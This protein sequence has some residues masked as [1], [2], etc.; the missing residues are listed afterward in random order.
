M[1]PGGKP[2]IRV[3]Q[4]GNRKV[5]FDCNSLLAFAVEPE[6][7][8]PLKEAF[9]KSVERGSKFKPQFKPM[10]PKEKPSTICL[11]VTHACNQCCLYCFQQS[12]YPEGGNMDF[13]TAKLAID[14]FFQP[15]E[16]GRANISF[17][18]G[19]PLL[20]WELIPWVV[21][22]TRKR[23]PDAKRLHFHITTN[24]TLL[25]EEKVEYLDRNNFSLIVSIDGP[26]YI[27]NKFRPMKSGKDSLN[28]TLKGL[29]LLKGRKIAKRT[30]LRGTFTSDYIR[31]RERLEYLNSL[32]E[33]GC[34][35]NVSVEP[36][37][38]NEDACVWEKPGAKPSR[39]KEI[40]SEYRKAAEW[41]IAR[42]KSGGQQLQ[43]KRPR[44]F[45]FEKTLE[46]ILFSEPAGTECGAGCGYLSFNPKGQIF[47]C[48]REH[49]TAIGHLDYGIDEE[50]R[51]K[52][53]ENR[54]YARKGCMD[55][56]ARYVCGGGCRQD[57]IEAGLTISEPNPESC[58]YKK[59]W[60]EMAL[61]IASELT[62]GELRWL[63]P[64][65]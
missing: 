31:L 47:A 17:F 63:F 16:T 53:V 65:K 25:D 27:H 2:E 43:K 15:D 13:F 11:E 6:D 30:T 51:A 34:A 44:F 59:V 12:H 28:A 41:F 9:E 35:A 56:W 14:R 24:G 36:A 38:L 7:P 40:T 50:K 61:Y 19:E 60:V 49:G 57:S 5:Y 10:R 29:L 39:L 3:F 26:H 37:C 46:R 62:E 32:V 55:C 4:F 52:W 45:H 1:I 21:N 54:I 23:F 18:G 20:N 48:H 33:K 42:V 64:K 8:G 22:Y 58:V